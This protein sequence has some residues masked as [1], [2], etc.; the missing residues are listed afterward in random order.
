MQCP[1]AK[2]PSSHRRNQRK[3][4]PIPPAAVALAVDDTSQPAPKK[5]LI[6]GESS[7]L[8]VN[9]KVVADVRM[10]V[11]DS[12]GQSEHTTEVEDDSSDVLS[13][14]SDEERQLGDEYLKFTKVLPRRQ[15]S[16]LRGK[17]LT[18]T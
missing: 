8:T 6:R 9:D 15:R 3:K 13:D 12:K 10:S 16:G 11:D 1:R 18:S 7:G 17:S 14:C 4:S 5:D 2:S